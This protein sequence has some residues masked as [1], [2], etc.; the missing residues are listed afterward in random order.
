MKL[1]PVNISLFLILF[2]HYSSCHFLD[3]ITLTNPLKNG[4]VLLSD[5]KT[6]ALGFFTPRNNPRNRY[7]GIWYKQVS[8]QTV[9]WVANRDNPLN[10]TTSGI[11]LI[12]IH[13]NIVLIANDTNNPNPIW[14]S[15]V[16]LSSSPTNTFAKLL[17]TGNLVLIEKETRKFVWQSFDYPYDT[18]LPF[19]KLGLEKRTGLNKFLTSWKSHDDPRPGNMR[20]KIDPR[21]Y[22]Q[23]FVYRNEDPIYRVGSWTGQRWGGIPEMIPN[24]FIFN[25]SFIDDTSEVCYTFTLKDPSALSRLVLDNTGHL[26][27]TTWQ[28]DDRRWQELIHVPR[29]N[30][31]HYRRC[32]SNSYCEEYYGADE[33]QC[34]CLPGFEPRNPQMRSGLGGGGCVRKKNVSTCQ[35]GEGFV[36]VVRV[37][38]PDTSEV[39]L[40]KSMSMSLKECEEKC[41]KDCSC[42]AYA[43]ANEVTLRGCLTWHTDMEDI[44]IF[45]STGQD[46]YVRVDAIELAKYENKRQSSLVKKGAVTLLVVSVFLL[47]L[48]ITFV[49]WFA[50]NKKQA[51]RRRLDEY[52]VDRAKG[53]DLTLFNLSEIIVATE[54]FSDTNKLGQGGFGSVYKGLLQNGMTIAV[55]R[56]SKHYGKG[57]EEFT[58]EVTLMEKLQHRNLVKILGCCIQGNEKLLIYEYLPNKSLDT[59]IFDQ[60]K[61]FKLDWK[62]RFDIISGVARGIL[63]LHHDSRLRIIHRDLKASNVLLDSALNPKISDFGIARI[64]GG[65]QIEASTNNVVGTYGYM[66]PEYAMEGLFSIKSDVYSFGVL[67]LEIVTGRKCHGHYDD[68]TYTLV[69]QIWEMWREGRT[70][71][72]V[73][74]SLRGETCLDE[75]VI[76]CINIGLLCVQDCASDRP[77]MLEVISMLDNDIVLPPP[78]QPGFMFKKTTC[79]Q[80]NT[81]A[82]GTEF[83][84]LNGMSTTEIE[85]R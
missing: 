23:F 65:N 18:M 76:K 9:V 63:Y 83:Y 80:S 75:Q 42:E 48:L 39:H 5:R 52:L 21:G 60:V 54:N 3:R 56:L 67:L 79:D 44:R 1:F 13:G 77:T 15:N 34:V 17:D 57:I 19:M 61:K 31:D 70:M 36:K 40:D 25:V 8:E 6:F 69:G 64:F 46:L 7:I 14:S 41:L 51:R 81:C 49:Y 66:S 62:K 53:S 11:F 30:C 59:F 78:K 24:Y 85:A 16:S 26:S 43:S 12:D 47:M 72:F 29:Q 84:S 74:P 2:V 4:D 38:L 28:P 37:K 82:S 33:F 22:P 10:G 55:K 71:D 35:S 27:R 58:N 20:Y 45:S 50:K 73:D 32:G 68:I